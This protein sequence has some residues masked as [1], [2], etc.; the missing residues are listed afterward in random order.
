MEATEP[1]QRE[2]GLAIRHRVFVEGQ[3]VPAALEVDA[4]DDACQ[5]VLAFIDEEPVGTA[6]YRQTDQGYKLERVAVMPEARRR[7][8]GEAIVA[9]VLS[10]LPPAARVYVHSQ[11]SAI[12]FWIAQGFVAEGPM[13][14]EASIPH[15]RM[16]RSPDQC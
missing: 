11:E 14:E 3:G 12:P 16:F 8:V 4:L 10:R 5:H 9:H 6:R 15:R 2:V 7:G 1:A 13:F